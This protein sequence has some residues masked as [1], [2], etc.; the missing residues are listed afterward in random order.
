MALFWFDAKAGI[1]LFQFYR[2]FRSLFREVFPFSAIF[3]KTPTSDHLS[4][5]YDVGKTPLVKGNGTTKR[6]YRQ[7]VRCLE[8]EKE[9][10]MS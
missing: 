7:K 2:L 5:R 1:A 4:Q 3:G 9:V 10:V 8:C 6:K